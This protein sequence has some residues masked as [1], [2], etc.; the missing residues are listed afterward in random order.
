MRLG[1]G[2]SS[3]LPEALAREALTVQ[4]GPGPGGLRTGFGWLFAPD[5]QTAL[6]GGAG[7]DSVALLRSRVR[8][9][10]THVILTSRAIT[11]ESIDDRLLQSGL[12]PLTPLIPSPR[13]I[14]KR[15]N[16]VPAL[17]R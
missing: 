14:D 12:T 2:W 1:T 10:R 9:R 8:D 13:H 17:P 3:L 11:I 4:A 16:H 7:L 15:G 6:H 5:D